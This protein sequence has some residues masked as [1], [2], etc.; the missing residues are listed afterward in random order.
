MKLLDTYLALQTGE[1]TIDE[2]AKVFG[3]NPKGLKIRLTKHGEGIQTV[4]KT[5]DLLAED[6]ITRD[7]AALTLGVSVRGVNILMNSWGVVRPIKAYAVDRAASLVKW[8]IRKKFSTDFIA[9]RLSLAQAA[10]LAGVSE[11]Q[12][13]RWVSELLREHMGMVYKDLATLDHLRLQQVA[14]A[15]VEAE[16]MSEET[17]RTADEVSVGKTTVHDEAEKRVIVLKRE[18]RLSKPPIPSKTTP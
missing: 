14:K 3:T 4:L 12:I 10:M 8:E 5:L 15:I 6:A 1:I 11:R 9:G 7:E 17:R 13:R 18:K 2:A 16:N